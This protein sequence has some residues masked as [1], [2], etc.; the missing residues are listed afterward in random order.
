MGWKLDA[1]RSTASGASP[2]SIFSLGEVKVGG[3]S[4]C[5]GSPTVSGSTS[6][7]IRSADWPASL[8]SLT[9]KVIAAWQ[10]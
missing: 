6:V 5:S 7:V 10:R 1:R 9:E 3:T 8:P 2:G 4:D